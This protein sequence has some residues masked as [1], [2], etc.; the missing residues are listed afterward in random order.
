MATSTIRNMRQIFVG[1]SPA[2]LGGG[3]STKGTSISG[4]AAPLADGEIGIFDDRGVVITNGTAATKIKIAVGRGTVDGPLV[5]DV[6]N[7]KDIKRMQRTV[8]VARANQTTNIGYDGVNAGTELEVIPNN[9]Y[10]VRLYI[11]EYLR[12]NSDGRRIKQGVFKS[13]STSTQAN[14]AQGLVKNFIENFKKEPEQ[15]IKFSA[16]CNVALASDFVFDATP[17]D[18]TGVRGSD[19]LLVSAASPTYNTG[20]AL[21]V[22]DFLRIGTAAG[23]VGA[24]A[25]ASD[26][27]RVIELPSTTTIK[28]DRPLQTVSGAYTVA[29]GGIT[30]IPAAL[31][32]AA[33]WGVRMLGQ[34]LSFSV[35]KFNYEVARWETGLE[36]FGSS[37]F[38]STGATKGNGEAE[39]VMQLEWFLKGS[40]GGEIYR[41][42]EPN[43]FPGVYEASLAVAGGGYDIINIEYVQSEL[44]AFSNELSP[45]L[46]TIAVPATA[47]LYA[48]AATTDDITDMLEEIAVLA[49]L[50]TVALSMT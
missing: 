26:V 15:F 7:V 43:I 22:G 12:S 6:I 4:G 50:G 19:T 8:H 17:F 27:Y 21:A 3:G 38:A 32:V 29:S 2:A 45:K 34:D 30:V 9:L 49:G 44:V 41:V 18:I 16:P 48:V 10:Y 5:S 36:N 46:I 28:L 39:E 42:G 11:Q 20:T 33:D 14:I 24:V 40:Q 1:G 25:L 47:P 23:I 35:G 31:G 37:T 13:T